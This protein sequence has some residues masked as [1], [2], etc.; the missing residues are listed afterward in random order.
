MVMEVKSSSK[1]TRVESSR[2]M[3][4]VAPQAQKRGA[5]QGKSQVFGLLGSATG[6]P[7]STSPIYYTC[8]QPGHMSQNCPQRESQVVCYTCQKPGHLAK[9][10]RLDVS[11]IVCFSCGKPGHTSKNYQVKGEQS[12][13]PQ[14][15]GRRGRRGHR[16]RRGGR[17]QTQTLPRQ[18]STE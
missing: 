9:D 17:W 14:G 15:R 4:S 1:R 11:S 3:S 8:F 12:G 7:S 16:G 10:C 13:T 18:S 5:D 2:S 6:T